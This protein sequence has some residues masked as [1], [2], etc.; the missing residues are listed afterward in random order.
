[1]DIKGALSRNL[2]LKIQT[3]ETATKLGETNMNNGSK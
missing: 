1:M 2:S 3:K